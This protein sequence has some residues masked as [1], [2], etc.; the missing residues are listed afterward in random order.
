MTR[1]LSIKFCRFGKKRNPLYRLGVLP[2]YR[3]PGKKFVT[4]FLGWYNP[5]TKESSLNKEKIEA[6]LSNNITLSD[7]VKSLLKKNNFNV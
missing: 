6:Y 1:S 7:S 4:E 5:K 2:I 3:H